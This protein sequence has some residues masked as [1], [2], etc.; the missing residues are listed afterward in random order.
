MSDVSFVIFYPSSEAGKKAWNKEFGMNAIYAG[1]HWSK[2]RKDAIMWHALTLD[3]INSANSRKQ[4]F[5]KP[6]SI[7]FLWNDR[8]DVSNHSYMAKLIED[9]M[10]GKLIVD[11]SKKWVKGI[12][13]YYHDAPYIKVRLRDV[14]DEE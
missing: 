14:G 13:H 7:T 4:P 10:K 11:D 12:E 8:M 1:K 6:V 3:A 2:R 5:E 9:G